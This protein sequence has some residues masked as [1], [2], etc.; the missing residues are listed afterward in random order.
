[1]NSFKVFLFFKDFYLPQLI[2]SGLEVGGT[3][4]ISKVKKSQPKKK[5]AK[6]K[7]FEGC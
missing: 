2:W 7:F 5:P 4:F 3:A 6:D 1:M